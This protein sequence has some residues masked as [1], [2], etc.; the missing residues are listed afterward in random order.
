MFSRH[1]DETKT[2]QPGFRISQ[3]KPVLCLLD[4]WRIS[5][6]SPYFLA[7]IKRNEWFASWFRSLCYKYFPTIFQQYSIRNSCLF[8]I[9]WFSVMLFFLFSYSIF[10]AYFCEKREQRIFLT[11][12]G[13]R[14]SPDPNLSGSETLM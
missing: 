1:N 2:C 13:S 8:H 7:V 5:A 9:W 3:A 14:K 11:G 10:S 6:G 12:S 4:I